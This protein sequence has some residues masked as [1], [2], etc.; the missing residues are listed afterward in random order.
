MKHELGSTA[1]DTITG[2]YGVITG[3]VNYL[4][5]CDQYLVQPKTKSENEF[6]EARWFDENRIDI[7]GGIE[8]VKIDTS[9][10]QGAC[11]AAP[12]K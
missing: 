2:F 8:K 11:G 3:R 5:G 1:R 9:T 4:T 7:L 10:A 6:V 12:I